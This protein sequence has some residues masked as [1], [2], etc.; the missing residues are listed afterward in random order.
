MRNPVI[1]ALDVPNLN[2]ARR[3]VELLAG[4]VGAFKVGME[5]FTA[6]GPEMVAAI[7]SRGDSVF[8][9]LKYHDIPNTVAGAV[10]AAVAL[11]V[12]MLTVHLQGGSAMLRAALEAV[13]EAAEPSG[14]EPPL[15]LGVSV[16]TGMDE[17]DLEEIGVGN[18]LPNQVD[19]LV[20]LGW[21]CGLRGF[22]CSPRE[23]GALRR[24]LPAGA[25]LVTPGIRM[26]ETDQDDQKR[27][28]S[29]AEA[30]RS[31]ADWIVVGRPV[32]AAADP[33][34]ALE[35]ILRSIR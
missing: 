23:A 14:G 33:L 6:A 12:Q 25:R 34:A 15:V 8:L 27:V 21:E 2:R 30:L 18:P 3:L 10:R 7:R 11:G 31:G 24:R 16:L 26:P 35:R 13:Q 19:R 5:L 4:R 20:D 28:T 32:H 29:P 1:V 17:R 9:D 22:V